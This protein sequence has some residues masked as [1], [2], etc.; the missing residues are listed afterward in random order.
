MPPDAEKLIMENIAKVCW[1]VQLCALG[2]VLI[3]V[4]RTPWT[5]TSILPYVLP[6]HLLV[7]LN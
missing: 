1:N 7:L 2:V 4:L 6:S 3:S 5:R